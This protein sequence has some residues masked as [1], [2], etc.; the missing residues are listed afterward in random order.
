MVS[1]LHS[2]FDI[3]RVFS[4]QGMD[5]GHFLCLPTSSG[6]LGLLPWNSTVRLASRHTL[7]RLGPKIKGSKQQREAVSS[8]GNELGRWPG[9]T[10]SAPHLQED[11]Q[12]HLCTA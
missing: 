5:L 3:L 9:L 6:Y 4:R 1:S 7:Y 2:N 8:I 11:L 12:V 10:T